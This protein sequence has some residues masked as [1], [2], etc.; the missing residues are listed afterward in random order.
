M[1]ITSSTATSEKAKLTMAKSTFSTGNT[2]RSILTFL[3]SDDA[4][5]MDTIPWLVESLMR[6]KVMLPRM[7]YSG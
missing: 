4:S 3:S 1:T 5:M 2:Q 6:A 7:M